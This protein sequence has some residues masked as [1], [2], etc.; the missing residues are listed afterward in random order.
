MGNF[1]SFKQVSKSTSFN[2]IGVHY[3]YFF[4]TCIHF[5]KIGNAFS[6]SFDKKDVL[7]PAAH[8]YSGS[9]DAIFSSEDQYPKVSTTEM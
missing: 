9:S 5:V 8:P 2:M 6:S 3:S 4:V 1:S 7:E